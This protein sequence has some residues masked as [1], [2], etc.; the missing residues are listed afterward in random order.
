MRRVEIAALD[1]GKRMIRTRPDA[2]A[3]EVGAAIRGHRRASGLTQQ[4]LAHTAGVSLGLVRDLEQGRTRSPRWGT[5]RVLAHAL[6]LDEQEC[7]KLLAAWELGGPRQAD[8]GQGPAQ[9]V[10][11]RILGP[12]A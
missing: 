3:C 2:R 6:G 5:V 1:A 10:Y 4:Q 9:P 8:H 11:V 12:L 7:A